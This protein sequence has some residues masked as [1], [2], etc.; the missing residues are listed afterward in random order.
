MV[1]TGLLDIDALPSIKGSKRS[2]RC[3]SARGRCT[4]TRTTPPSM[5]LTSHPFCCP[6][7][8]TC[9]WWTASPTSETSSH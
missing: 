9:Q 7:M 1:H 3:S 5:A 8:A 2:P 6:A 4:C